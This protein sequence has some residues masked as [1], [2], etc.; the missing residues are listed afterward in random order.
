MWFTCRT[1]LLSLLSLFP[2]SLARKT[3]SKSTMAAPANAF[4]SALQRIGFNART[5]AVINEN[6]FETILD[7]ATVQEDDLNRL[8]KHLEAW[9]DPEAGP[10]NQVRIPFV[11]LKKLKAMC[12]WVLAQHCIRNDDPRAQD[13]MDEVMEETLTRMQANSDAKMATKETEIS[14]PEKL[15]DLAKWTKFWE[16]LST[17][18]GILG[19]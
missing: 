12:Y 19:G 7:L 11:S 15:A 6:G 4:C 8:P 16:L 17:Y 18:L 5:H 2:C 13:F 14:K 3:S 1:Q 10:N 9:R